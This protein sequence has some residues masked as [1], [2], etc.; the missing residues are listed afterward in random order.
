MTFRE[1]RGN[2]VAASK[3]GGVLFGVRSWRLVEA[4]AT[5]RTIEVLGAYPDLG[6]D[7]S[8]RAIEAEDDAEAGAAARAI[9]ARFDL[10][11][12]A[13]VVSP[14]ARVV[15]P[16]ELEHTPAAYHG[17]HIDVTAEWDRGFERSAFAV[18]RTTRAAPPQHA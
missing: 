3:K 4:R 15:S 6:D 18:Q 5:G 10:P 9:N 12:D 11:R 7:P 8:L 2:L 16:E 13:R 1:V 17:V 14:D